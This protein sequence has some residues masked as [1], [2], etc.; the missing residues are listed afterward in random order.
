MN[1]QTGSNGSNG[2]RLLIPLKEA[3]GM[4]SM[5]RQTLMEYVKK[6]TLPCI[7]LARN[8]VYFRPSDLE[9]FI[10]SREVQYTPTDIP[11]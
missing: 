5:C 2:Q 3:A 11:A 7:R 1:N 4:L 6:G 9:I 10:D 8:S